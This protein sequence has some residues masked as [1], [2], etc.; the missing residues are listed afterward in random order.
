MLRH[1]TKRD[2]FGHHVSRWSSE[3]AKA[4]MEIG[5]PFIWPCLDRVAT[6]LVLNDVPMTTEV[7]KRP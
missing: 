5:D 4:T 3:A 1:G 6:L 2:G 7:D